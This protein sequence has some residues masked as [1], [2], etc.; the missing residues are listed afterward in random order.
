MEHTSY[1]YNHSF[2]IILEKCSTC[3]AYFNINPDK[4]KHTCS[5]IPIQSIDIIKQMK[6]NMQPKKGIKKVRN[7]NIIQKEDD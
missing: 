3:G 7:K 2:E 1:S 4:S 5:N 6:T